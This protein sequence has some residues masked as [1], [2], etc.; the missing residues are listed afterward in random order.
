MSPWRSIH[1]ALLIGAL[2]ANASAQ[3]RPLWELGVGVAT[4]NLPYYR[5][6]EAQR[7]YALPFP[8]LVYRG[9]YLNVDKDGMR[10][11]L[12]RRDDL[13][14]DLSLAAGVPVP[15]DQNGP[16]AGMPR[17]DPTV[18]FG[19]SLEYRLWRSEDRRRN[20]WL[21]LPLRGAFAIGDS[22]SQQGWLFAPYLELSR[23]DFGRSGWMNS[24][25]FGPLFADASYHDYFY[26][27]APQYATATRPAYEGHGGYNGSRITLITGKTF[28]QLWLSAFVRLDT[29]NGAAFANSPLVETRSYHIV[30]VALTW[31]FA[32]S[33]T[34]VHA[35]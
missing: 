11:W 33:D 29:L 28:D 10:G 15:S 12:Y 20:V 5:G 24:I 25:A 3:E 8:Y 1:S 26:G 32:R 4:L 19:P 6:S 31:I 17:L 14:L 21:R 16:R 7:S 9:E 30:G 34:R 35:P 13:S 2:A 23:H 27:V 18:E 22:I